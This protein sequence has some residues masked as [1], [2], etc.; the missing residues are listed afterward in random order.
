M[1]GR[2]SFTS[3]EPGQARIIIECSG[4]PE[5]IERANLYI[6]PAL[7]DAVGSMSQW[8]SRHAFFAEVADKD[9]LTALQ[10]T[11]AVLDTLR[12][13]GLLNLSDITT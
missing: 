1:D 8:T 11:V 3:S 9:A 7:G 12:T 5:E 6:T 10:A 13:N 2:I 4:D